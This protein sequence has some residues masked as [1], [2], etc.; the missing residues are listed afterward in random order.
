MNIKPDIGTALF[1]PH[2]INNTHSGFFHFCIAAEAPVIMHSDHVLR[3]FPHPLEI[4]LPVE[5]IDI[6]PVKNRLCTA[7]PACVAV[8]LTPCL[9]TAVKTV[10]TDLDIIDTDILGQIAVHIK[11]N[12]F[13]CHLCVQEHI[14]G[15]RACMH[16]GICPTGANN[17]HRILRLPP[18]HQSQYCL[19]SSLDRQVRLLLVFPAEISGSVI[20]HNKFEI[21]G[22]ICCGALLT[23][24]SPGILSC[25]L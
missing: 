14:A 2:N 19:E 12:L 6:A 21:S 10:C 9:E 5:H 16:S 13:L 8:C 17:R 7:V 11:L 1:D 24:F 23:G 22:H 3:S 20:T 18:F 4:G 25:N 15:H